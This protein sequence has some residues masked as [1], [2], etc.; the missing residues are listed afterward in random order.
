MNRGHFNECFAVEYFFFMS[1]IAYYKLIIAESSQN[2]L[3]II[4][5]TVW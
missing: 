5:I 1:G 3:E 2:S 4:D